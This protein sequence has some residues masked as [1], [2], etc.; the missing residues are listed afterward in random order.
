MT[1]TDSEKVS[2]PRFYPVA[3]GGRESWGVIWMFDG[4][5]ITHA[6]ITQRRL[7]PPSHVPDEGGR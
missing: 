1:L 4:E 5:R 2:L 3:K 6:S 7:K